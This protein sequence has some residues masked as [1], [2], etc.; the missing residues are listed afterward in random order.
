[1]GGLLEHTDVI[2]MVFIPIITCAFAFGG[3]AFAFRNNVQH[4]DELKE[5]IEK[6]ERKI[7]CM[8]TRYLTDLKDIVTL[9]HCENECGICNKNRDAARTSLEKKIDEIRAAMVVYEAN[10]NTDSG[11]AN[12][13]WLEIRE[14]LATLLSVQDMMKATC[15]SHDVLLRERSS[16]SNRIEELEKSSRVMVREVQHNR[17]ST[18]VEHNRRITDVQGSSGETA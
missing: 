11:K 18:D 13:C 17:R 12:N 4:L 6:M 5:T 9:E 15:K 3:A 10:R 14:R 1:M 7:N 2:M 8:E 16:H